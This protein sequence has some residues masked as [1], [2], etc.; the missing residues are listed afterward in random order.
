MYCKNCGR[1][2]PDQ[3]VICVGCGVSAGTG[4]KYCSNCGKETNENA[5]VCLACGCELERGDNG[6]TSKKEKKTA[7]LFALFIG[8]WGIHEFYLGYHTRGIIRVIAFF[9]F[10]V[11]FFL[12]NDPLQT[13]GAL[14][15]MGLNV[16][17]IIEIIQIARGK[18][19]DAKGNDLS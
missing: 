12:F 6:K 4:S 5:A 9:L 15:I 8:Q 10:L 13:I 3:A 19:K 7:L 14:G 2:I 11:L 16:W 17:T 18:M 1:E